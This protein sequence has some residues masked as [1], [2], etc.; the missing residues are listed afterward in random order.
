MTKLDE[1]Y[2]KLLILHTMS[3]T[4]DTTGELGEDV[5]IIID[6]IDKYVDELEA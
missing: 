6:L 3:D 2:Q 1:A 4:I 5:R